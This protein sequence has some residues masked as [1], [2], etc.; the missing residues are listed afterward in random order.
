MY[1]SDF[2]AEKHAAAPAMFE[3]HAHD[4]ITSPERS[5]CILI[6]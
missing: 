6:Q 3:Q 5:R 1:V 4:Q 2:Q